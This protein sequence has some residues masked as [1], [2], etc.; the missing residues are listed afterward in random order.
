MCTIEGLS[1]NPAEAYEQGRR[2]GQA[3]VAHATQL[4]NDHLKEAVASIQKEI[5]ALK[6]RILA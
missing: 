5:I 2:D 3:E 6:E 4:E 1:N